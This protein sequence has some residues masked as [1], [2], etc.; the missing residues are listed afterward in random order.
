M[1]WRSGLPAQLDKLLVYCSVVVNYKIS[2]LQRRW[3]LTY[4]STYVTT[5]SFVCNL[6]I[7]TLNK[8]QSLQLLLHGARFTSGGLTF[9]LFVLNRK[10]HVSYV[11]T[12]CVLSTAKTKWKM[13][14]TAQTF[15]KMACW[16][17][18]LSPCAVPLNYLKQNLD[19]GSHDCA[20]WARC[21]GA[22]Q[23]QKNLKQKHCFAASGSDPSDV[24][25]SEKL[26][27]WGSDK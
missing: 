5:F 4:L 19:S 3:S 12:R 7:C 22:Q 14:S 15:P 23:W 13:P 2:S 25:C 16:R 10:C 21:F 24:N 26:L 18:V 17:C 9:L 27:I 20:L 1:S 8:K 6:I 11:Q